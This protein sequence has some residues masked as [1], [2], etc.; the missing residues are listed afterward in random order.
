MKKFKALSAFIVLFSALAFTSC[1]TEPVDSELIGNNPENPNPN[2][3]NNPNNPGNPTNPGTSTGNYW[4]FAIGNEWVFVNG[5]GEES[6]TLI[7]STAVADGMS[8]YKV[9]SLFADAG[10]GD[11]T[12]EATMLLRHNNG[13]YRVRV[14]VEVPSTPGMPSI[15]V[16]PYEYS[17][18]KDYLDVGQTWSENVTQ[19]T[20]YDMPGFPDII[21]NLAFQGTILEKDATVTVNGVTYPNVIKLKLVQNISMQGQNSSTTSIIWFAKDVGPLFSAA[22]GLG[23]EFSSSLIDYTLN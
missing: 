6:S 22:E 13:D 4:P 11:L 7:S 12:G 10:T 16:S 17:I 21:T 23:A 9:S 8:Y 18:L 20:S 19:T 15:S 2:N 1:D 5:E 3:P 14:S